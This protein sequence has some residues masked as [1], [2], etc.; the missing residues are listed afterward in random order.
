MGQLPMEVH[1]HT[2]NTCNLR[3]RHCYNGSG[4]GVE[5]QLLPISFVLECLKWFHEQYDVH[6]HLE[7]GEI[8]LRE[9]L[10][11]TM[12]AL[13][14]EV[15]GRITITTNGT[16]A[17]NDPETLNM[18]RKLEVLRVSVE[19]HTNA[20]QQAVR[21][22]DLDTVLKNAAAYRD[23]GVPV[24]LRVTLNSANYDGF[25]A[26]TLPALYDRGFRQIQVYEFQRVGRGK[27]NC[28]LALEQ[29]V[30]QFLTELA[31]NA[32]KIKRG[33]RVMFPIG[34]RAEVMA[35]KALLA[36]AGFAVTDIESES[37]ISI[38]ANG[39]VY[40]CP[41]EE[42]AD[43][44]VMNILQTGLE[45]LDRK[46]DQMELVHTCDHCSALRVSSC[47]EVEQSCW[48]R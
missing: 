13:P 17:V 40:L 41:W 43:R 39:D 46:L 2:N 34:R 9:D 6:F 12:N 33:L 35:H 32:D 45:G 8:F 38:H 5:P 47:K 37:S 18:L 26:E 48:S 16:I 42:S 1:L 4:C 22:I 27:H 29:G 24:S 19:G 11:A 3:C 31:S 28:M 20:Q 23:A 36:Q 15:L 10:L 30:D 7:G 44:C 25:A 21:R 14:N